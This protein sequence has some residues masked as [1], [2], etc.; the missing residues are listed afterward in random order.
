MAEYV[1]RLHTPEGT[2]P[3]HRT[4]TAPIH[5]QNVMKR[6]DHL[7]QNEHLCDYTIIAEGQSFRAH[8]NVLAAVSDYFYAMLT[9]A[10][11]ESRQDHVDLK[12]VSANAVKALLD[13]A[14]NGQLSLNLEDVVEILAGACHLQMSSAIQLCSDFLLSEISSKTCV[15]I[16]NISE[17]FALTHVKDVCIGYCIENLDKI[18]DIDQ[19]FKLSKEHLQIILQSNRLHCE[20][21]LILFDHIVSWIEY[22]I[23]TRLPYAADLFKFIRFSL[24]RPE[25]LVDHVAQTNVMLKDASS[26]VYLDE[27]LHYHVLP[28][29][30]PLIQN[31]RTQVRNDQCMVAF[32]GRYGIS[33][34]YKHNCNKMFALHNGKWYKLPN[35]DSNFLYAS[36]A[37]VDN[38]MY[39]CGGMG[40][41]AHARATCQ[42]Y[43]PRVGAWTRIS[44]MK[45]RRQSFPLV[46]YKAHLYALGGGTPVEHGLE[47]PPT[48]KCEV[49][50][51]DKNEWNFIAPLPEK[52]KSSSACEYMGKIY[53]SGG[54][55]H[56]DTVS[57]V[58]CYDVNKDTWESK[59]PMLMAHAGHAMLTIEDNIYVI[60][61]TN[62][63]IESYSPDKDEWCKVQPPSGSV[64]GVARPAVMGPW[65]YFV[66]YVEENKD[67]QCRRYNI[68]TLEAEELPSFPENVH[69]VIGAPL[70][71]P[72]VM[73]TDTNNNNCINT[74][75]STASTSGS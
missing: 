54:R 68:L 75:S 27:A 5:S 64:A 70:A 28:S 45:I 72:R 26:R 52:R 46:A 57:T 69:C 37:V 61:R 60:D 14:Y 21:E 59:S 17:M 49:Y 18:C 43:D 73:L 41:P 19:F 10:M 31:S 65:V 1:K 6:I 48:D 15:D 25:E 44:H 62:L 71:F 51:I 11:I 3:T 29:R 32:G 67:Y 42:R 24:M 36:V 7:F 66:S 53:V 16:L 35:T 34:G 8:R 23:T 47:H 74:S 30:H 22:D 12:G 33:I 63:S 40:K 20:T 13:F 50:S 2:P 38:F 56:N 55:T 39:A 58:W 9:G 4:L